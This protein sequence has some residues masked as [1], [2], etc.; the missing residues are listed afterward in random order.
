MRRHYSTEQYAVYKQEAAEEFWGQVRW[1]TQQAL[2]RMLEADSEQQ[3]ADYLGLAPYERSEEP[4][5][6][7]DSRNG[8]YERDYVTAVGSLRIRVRRTRK[9]SF[10]PRG[11]HTLERRAT[12]EVAEMIRQAFL[13]GM[14]TRAVGRVVAL[15][16]DEPV[17]AQTVS[18]LTRVLDREVEK[19]HHAPLPDDWSYLLLDGVW[20]K[21]RRAFGPQRVLLL[22]AYGVRANG[23]RQLLGFTRA[24][25]ESQAA[26]EGFLWDLQQRAGLCGSQLQFKVL[27]DGC[28]GTG[29]G[30]RNHLSARA[31]SVVGCTRCATC[32]TACAGAIRPPS[33]TTP[34]ASTW[35]GTPRRPAGPSRV[36]VSTGRTLTR[37]WSSLVGARPARTTY[38]FRLPTQPLWR[39]LRTTNAIERCFRSKSVAAHDPLMVLFTNVQSVERIVYAIFTDS[40][41]NGKTAT[42]LSLFTQAA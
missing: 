5:E 36:S 30:H 20:M 32:A 9:R 6:R 11:I 37:P 33:S 19:F 12:P 16:T 29:R 27:T 8:Y 15:L 14:S 42:H 7:V 25:G 34:S 2:Q 3:M 17:S 22:V 39:K 41:S 18:R 26:W 35:R 21:V 1:R 28:A 38:V 13:R 40:I 31:T 23:Q 24:R 4:G 10:L